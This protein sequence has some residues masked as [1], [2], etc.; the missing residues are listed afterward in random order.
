MTRSGKKA[1]I[2][3]GIT[4]L[5]VIIFFSTNLHKKIFNYT[6][7]KRVETYLKNT[8]GEDYFKNNFRLKETYMGTNLLPIANGGTK[9]YKYVF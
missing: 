6:T 9:Y 7:D 3:L 1:A 2:I 8:V 4:L 5:A